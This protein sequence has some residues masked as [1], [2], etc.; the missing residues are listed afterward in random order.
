MMALAVY[1]WEMHLSIDH[2]MQSVCDN[3][4]CSMIQFILVTKLCSFISCLS[5]L[6]NK[7]KHPVLKKMKSRPKLKKM[8]PNLQIQ[9][10]ILLKKMMTIG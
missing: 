4:S 8:K 1:S 5:F 3:G 10:M 2:V 6:R 7:R 9:R